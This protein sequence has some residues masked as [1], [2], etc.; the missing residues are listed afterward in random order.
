M[1]IIKVTLTAVLSIAALFV[2]TKIM[3][4]KQVSQLDF[5]DYICGITIGSIGAELATELEEPEKPLIALCVYG[6]VSVLQSYITTKIPSSRKYINGAPLIL[7]QCGKIYR[8]SLKKAKLDLTELM[9]LAREQGYFDLDAI[10]VAV[11]EHT[12]KISILPKSNLRPTTPEDLSLSVKRASIGVELIMDGKIIRKNLGRI[13][14][15][16]DWLA[17]E[18]DLRGFSSARE[19]LLAVYKKEEDKL[20]IYPMK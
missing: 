12:G 8:E 5:F 18:L 9:L 6:I 11:F 13:A 14:K 10:E 15:S 4:H 20:T 17:S 3:G 2:I 1:D 7:I 16:E 19:I